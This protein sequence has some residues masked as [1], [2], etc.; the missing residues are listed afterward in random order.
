V[1]PPSSPAPPK[2]TP[3]ARFIPREELSTFEAWT[4]GALSRDANAPPSPGHG[5]RASDKGQDDSAAQLRAARQAGYQDGYRDGLVA[6][7]GFKQSFAQATTAQVG[8]LLGSVGTQLDALQQQM[9]SAIADAATR[10]AEQIVRSELSTRP[11]LVADVASQAL[12]ALMLSARH[13]TLRVHPDDQPLVAQG[14]HDVLAARGARLIADPAVQ[15]GGCIVDSDI[16]HID[17]SL[18]SR[19]RRSVAALGS[20]RAWDDAPSPAA[21]STT[22]APSA[23]ETAVEP[24]A[25]DLAAEPLPTSA[26]PA[27]TAEAPSDA[28]LGGAAANPGLS[29]PPVDPNAP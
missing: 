20:Q 25:T 29:E 11:E 3:Y 16:A 10:L 6:L 13:I 21:I 22:A 17:A 28:G 7:D 12:D 1:P 15:R 19:W 9:A 23:P 26:A 4:P 24:S 8:Q 5:R 18:E 14:A 27:P 2:S